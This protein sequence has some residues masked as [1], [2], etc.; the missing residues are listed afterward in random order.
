MPWPDDLVTLMEDA[1]A[2]TG[3]TDIFVGPQASIPNIAAGVITIRATSGS[4]PERT[5][6]SVTLPAY[7]NP[8]AQIV[9]RAATWP[10]A[11]EKARRAYNAVIGVRNQI[12]NGGFYREINSL[13]EP[14]DLP[15]EDR[16]QIA[17]AF[18]VTAT[19]R[20]EEVT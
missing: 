2:G 7:I 15:L 1:G 4:G 3:G 13:Q 11:Q 8:S 12:I 9:I 14:F 18:N 6:N 19:K 16:G 5:H 20:S 17:Q 10:A